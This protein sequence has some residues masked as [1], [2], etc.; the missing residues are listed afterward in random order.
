MTLSFLSPVFLAGLAAAIVPIVIHLIHRQRAMTHR[1]P[2]LEFIL[3]SNR[4][5]ARALRLKEILLVVL[6]TASVAL[7]ALGFA[8]PVLYA[9]TTLVSG[10]GP[11]SILLVLDRSYSMGY[12]SGGT[13]AFERARSAARD[14]VASLRDEDEAMILACGRRPATVG[15][16]WSS[17]REL[18]RKG[19]DGLSLSFEAGDLAACLERAGPLLDGAGR[20]ERSMVLLSDLARGG[21]DLARLQGIDRKRRL[22]VLDVGAPGPRPNVAAAA[23]EADQ[24]AEEGLRAVRVRAT[25]RNFSP[26]AIRDLPVHAV[27][28]GRSSVE[29][30]GFVDLPP[31]GEATKEFSLPIDPRQEPAGSLFG[32]VEIRGDALPAD[33]VRFFKVWIRSSLRALLVDGDPRPHLVDSETF[34]LE[35]ALDP[36]KTPTSLV[37]PEV[38]DPEGLPGRDLKGYDLLVLANVGTLPREVVERIREFVRSGGGLFLSVGDKVEPDRWN[39][40]FGDLLP[41]PLWSIRALAE[42]GTSEALMRSV[43]FE[44]YTGEHPLLRP[45]AHPKPEGPRLSS[46][47]CLRHALLKPTPPREGVRV[48]L[49]FSDGAPA[50]VEKPYGEGR[51][52]LFT[53][54]IDRDWTDFPIRPVY[55]PLV[56]QIAQYLARTLPAEGRREWTPGDAPL[57]PVEGGGRSAAVSDPQ[58]GTR[59]APVRPDPSGFS[60]LEVGEVSW[61]GVWRVALGEPGRFDFAVNLDPKE[62]DLAPIDRPSLARALGEDRVA[63][64]TSPRIASSSGAPVERPVP[65]EGAAFALLA[66]LL[67]VEGVVAV[68]R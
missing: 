57:L 59:T 40:V 29:A 34:Y 27:L 42:P 11:R 22:W 17:D 28:A 61:P 19:I 56:Q 18:L 26:E 5:V 53:S 35:R 55:V 16:G 67:I 33:D 66:A 3:R 14:L 62:G 9:R 68:R 43:H 63:F 60:N 2:A 37:K 20:P 23:V 39:E 54:S 15:T 32:R 10:G 58:G 25:I 38:V 41:E 24:S 31:D 50:L 47:S 36:V 48:V 46:V 6:R 30:R 44:D 49:K 13:T 12:R 1:F 4:R 8:R 52:L 45:L 64:L 7:L 21:V 51:V 65:L